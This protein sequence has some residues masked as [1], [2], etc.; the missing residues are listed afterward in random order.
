MNSLRI[1]PLAAILLCAAACASGQG[2]VQLAQQ[3]RRSCAE[4]GLDP[5]SAAFGSCV[6]NLDATMFEQN[7]AAVR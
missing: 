1:L 4:L 2:Q 3:E 6:G 7:N 5:G